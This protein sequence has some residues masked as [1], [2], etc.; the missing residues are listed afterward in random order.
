MQVEEGLVYI[1]LLACVVKSSTASQCPVLRLLWCVLVLLQLSLGFLSAP[2]CTQG[3]LIKFLDSVNSLFLF[4]PLLL[5][6]SSSLSNLPYITDNLGWFVLCLLSLHFFLIWIK[7]V[8]MK[9]CSKKKAGHIKFGIKCAVANESKIRKGWGK[10]L[11]GVG[12][13]CDWSLGVVQ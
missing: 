5:L 13:F 7:F 2:D 4:P 3:L 9:V 12:N 8:D 6:S 1:A 10:N 11:N